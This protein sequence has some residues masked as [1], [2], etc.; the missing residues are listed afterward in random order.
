MT[1]QTYE[2][3]AALDAIGAATPDEAA[4]LRAHLAECPDCLRAADEYAEAA[5]LLA[6]G[7]DPVPPPPALRDRIAAAVGGD[8]G[9][10]VVDASQRF[11]STRWLAVAAAVFLALWG[12][13]ELSVRV[14]REHARTK[15]AEIA[16]RQEENA[17]LRSQK[18]KLSSEIEAL[19]SKGTR[20]IALAGQP[21]SPSASARVFLEPEGHRAVVF[22]YDLPSNPKDKSYQLWIIRADQPKPQSAGVFDVTQNGRATVSI[23]NLPVDTQIKALAVTLESKGGVAQPTNSNFFVM[24]NT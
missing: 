10:E 8:D 5:T 17:Q 22:F 13:R 24:G 12:W 21:V 4:Q 6:R 19:A 14:A 7:I 11:R 1:H 18:E 20:T 16:Q 3:I 9:G 23:E 15:D 2:S